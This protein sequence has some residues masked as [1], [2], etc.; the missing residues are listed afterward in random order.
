MLQMLIML[1]AAPVAGL[2]FLGAGK[3]LMKAPALIDAHVRNALLKAG[4]L[5]LHHLAEA[6]VADFN[7]NLKPE[8]LK[9]AADGKISR[10]D[11]EALLKLAIERI[12]KVGGDELKQFS[13]VVIGGIV[14]SHVAAAKR[15][16]R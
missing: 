12:K 6:T 4:L 16:P 1:L 15:S 13:D 2:L 7:A 10:E 11:G 9:R 3:L 8:F 14:E 5:R